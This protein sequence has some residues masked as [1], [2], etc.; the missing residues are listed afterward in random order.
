MLNFFKNQTDD[1][2]SLADKPITISV[3]DVSGSGKTRRGTVHL[4]RSEREPSIFSR[5]FLTDSTGRAVFYGWMPANLSN[6][7]VNLDDTETDGLKLA[8]RELSYIELAFRL[9]IFS[10]QTVIRALRLLMAGNIRGFQFRMVRLL[11]S[12]IAPRYSDWRHAQAP[13]ETPLKVQDTTTL[14]VYSIHGSGDAA[15]STRRSMQSQSYPRLVE[16]PLP[17]HRADLPACDDDIWLRIPAGVGLDRDYV[18]RLLEPLH[19][20]ED[21]VAVYCDEEYF[22][23]RTRE[24]KPF[25][26]P[27]FNGPLAKSGWLAPDAAL[28]RVKSLPESMNLASTTMGNILFDVS[29]TGLI[30]H[31]PLPLFYRPA[32]RVLPAPPQKKK[33]DKTYHVSVVIPTRDRADLLSRCLLGLF[34]GT[35]DVNLDVIV[36][37]NDSRNIDALELMSGYE[38]EGLIRRLVMPGQFNFSKACNLGVA[39][40]KHELVLLLNNDVEPL[41]SD[42]LVQMAQEL[43]HESVGACGALLLFPDGFIQHGGVTL[44]MGS[45]AR[46]SFHFKHPN[47]SENLGLIAQRREVSAVTAACLLTRKSLWTLVDGMNEPALPVAFNDVDYCLKLLAQGKKILWTPYARLT[48]LESVSRRSDDTPEKMRRFAGEEKYMHD[49]WGPLLQN[50]PYYNPNLSLYGDDYTL[51]AKPR[52][53]RC[54]TTDVRRIVQ[55]GR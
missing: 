16:V 28:I 40:A 12:M 32:E 42:W 49:H 19:Q 26:K 53:R 25:F 14:V 27:A 36:I 50:D 8:L 41:H 39:A 44:G 1:I 51:D 37:D 18:A 23:E 55:L 17:A 7:T 52:D 21:I 4:H 33:L 29:R 43:E 35:S 6:I 45:V 31:I 46:H 30:G 38:R 2:C 15:E 22:D 3:R 10:P 13:E 48:H 9:F 47:S 5:S 11:D 54:R 24:T 34:K 20:E